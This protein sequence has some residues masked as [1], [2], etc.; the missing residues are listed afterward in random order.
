MLNFTDIHSIQ[1]FASRLYLGPETIMPLASILAA[2]LGVI[3]IFWRFIKKF[4]LRLFKLDSQESQADESE[5][6]ID[7][8]APEALIDPDL[9]EEQHKQ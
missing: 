1:W 8:D 3:L 6:L 4:I 5:A 7:P 9:Q 2:L